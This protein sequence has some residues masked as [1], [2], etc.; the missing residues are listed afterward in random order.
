MNIWLFAFSLSIHGREVT[1][2]L[3]LDKHQ[4]WKN[5]FLFWSVHFSWSFPGPV[6][7]LDNICACFLQ[8]LQLFSSN[9]HVCEIL[10]TK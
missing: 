8:F 7:C 9:R 6:E 1:S 2:K 4:K 5:T 3:N 10:N